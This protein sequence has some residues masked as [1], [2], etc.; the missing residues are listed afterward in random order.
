MDRL[1]E[2][3]S[4][5]LSALNYV[6]EEIDLLISEDIPRYPIERKLNTIQLKA[7]ARVYGDQWYDVLALFRENPGKAVS[8]VKSRLEQKAREWDHVKSQL[9]QSWRATFQENFYKAL[10]YRSY[11]F[12][13][14]EK[15]RLASK[16]LISELQ[17]A[18]H[19]KQRAK[20]IAPSKFEIQS[21]TSNILPSPPCFTFAFPDQEV[22]QQLYKIVLSAARRLYT[23]E[24]V[25]KVTFIQ[26]FEN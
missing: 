20:L 7:I 26:L 24:M 16:N 5:A 10:D 17:Q 25:E 19:K 1:I 8:L 13:T 11:S 21:Q 15:K 9:K 18:I 3:N 22:H 6:Q 12:K 2:A 14:E 4:D 23:D